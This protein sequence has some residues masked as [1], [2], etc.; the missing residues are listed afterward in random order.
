MR[1][2][3]FATSPR[4]FAASFTPTASTQHPSKPP[5]RVRC[6]TSVA[7]SCRASRSTML[8]PPLISGRKRSTPTAR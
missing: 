5:A 4:T 2:E 1:A 8:R 7:F 3:S 6:T